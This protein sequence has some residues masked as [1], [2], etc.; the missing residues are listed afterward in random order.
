MQ[1]ELLEK[2]SKK[3]LTDI[4][5]MIGE[6]FVTNELFHEFGDIDSRRELV[7]KYMDIYTDFVYESHALYISEDRKG[8]I[9]YLSSQ[10]TPILPQIK[11]LVRLFGAIPLKILKKFMSHIKQISNSNEKYAKKPHI[12]ILFVCVDKEYQGKGYAKALVTNAQE[13]AKKEKLPLLFDT[14]MER[15]ARIYEHYGCELYN[16]TTASNGVTRYNL[17]WKENR[18][19]V[20]RRK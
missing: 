10:K 4:K 1:I 18:E 6:A 14:D 11:M 2:A 15:Y 13:F 8:V 12:D 9:G 16:Q 7:L 5:R 19:F 20:Q 3:E 17:V